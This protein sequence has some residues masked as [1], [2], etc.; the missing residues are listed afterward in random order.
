MEAS[1]SKMVFKIYG[2]LQNRMLWSPFSIHCL[3]K[4][5][6][7]AAIYIFTKL[8]YHITVVEQ[9]Q[10]KRFLAVFFLTLIS[11]SIFMM[12][13]KLC[14]SFKRK[15]YL[16]ISYFDLADITVIPVSWR[17]KKPGRSNHFCR[18]RERTLFIL[19]QVLQV[20]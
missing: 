15:A 9:F 12:I 18:F 17:R 7:K 19:I 2:K 8:N 1:K 10:N 14:Y 6:W 5:V 13:S 4:V 16:P 3:L 20:C 11:T